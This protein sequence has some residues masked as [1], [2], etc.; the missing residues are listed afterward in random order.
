MPAI[1]CHCIIFNE[2]RV[3]GKI[4]FSMPS[5]VPTQK[6][7]TKPTVMFRPDPT[8]FPSV[9]L[10]FSVD[11][12]TVSHYWDFVLELRQMRCAPAEE[13]TGM[14][15]VLHEQKASAGKVGYATQLQ[16]P[17]GMDHHLHWVPFCASLGAIA[18]QISNTNNYFL[19]AYSSPSS[20]VWQDTHK[21]NR[22]LDL[23]ILQFRL[24]SPT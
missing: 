19:S 3:I 23:T 16:A 17:W 11:Y 6:G 20:S 21:G 8:S 1:R 9:N 2:L 22:W 7:P 10:P 4:I 12:F 15:L 14:T 5:G 18:M 13:G 24:L